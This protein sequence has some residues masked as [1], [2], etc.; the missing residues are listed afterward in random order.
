MVVPFDNL[1]SMMWTVGISAAI[2]GIMLLKTRYDSTTD[3]FEGTELKDRIGYILTFGGGGLYLFISGL[4]I[5]F[6]WPY[7]SPFGSQFQTGFVGAYNNVLFGGVAT[8]GGLLLVILALAL[9][10]NGGFKI[11]SYVGVGFGAYSLCGAYAIL[12]NSYGKTP[13]PSALGYIGFAAAAF[14]IVPV[15]HSNNKGLR[16]LAALFAFLFAAVWLFEGFNTS[17]SHLG[18]PPVF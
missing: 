10:Y 4:Y 18:A 17:L 7:G 12:A 9:Y 3:S 15:T 14:F 8:L 11:A 13:I 16:Y 2:I 5:Y 6:T 1:D